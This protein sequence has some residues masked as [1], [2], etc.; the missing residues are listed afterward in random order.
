MTPIS[1]VIYYISLLTSY[2]C[3]LL[4]HELI[5]LLEE[6]VS[7]STDVYIVSPND[8]YIAHVDSE[9]SDDEHEANPNHF[10]PAI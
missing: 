4:L 7:G 5:V 3:R 2:L 10:V 8:S 9:K 6:D 1:D